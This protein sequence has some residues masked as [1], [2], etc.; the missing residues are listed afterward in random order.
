MTSQYPGYTLNLILS[1]PYVHGF[2]DGSCAP[3]DWDDWYKILV[4]VGEALVYLHKLAPIRVIHSAVNLGNVLLDESL[5][6]KLSG[7]RFS[8]CFKVNEPDYIALDVIRGTG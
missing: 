7:F 2:C 1:K 6:P 8:R 4:G 5:V 3:L